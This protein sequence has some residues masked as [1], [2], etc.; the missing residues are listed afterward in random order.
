MD[1]TKANGRL[2]QAAEQGLHKK[3]PQPP[4][5]RADA[6]IWAEM[7]IEQEHRQGPWDEGEAKAGNWL[8]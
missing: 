1:R 5:I 6:E 3:N 7:D 4:Q 2:E 8:V